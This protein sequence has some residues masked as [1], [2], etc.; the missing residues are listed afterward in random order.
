MR[1]LVLMSLCCFGAVAQESGF[2]LEDVARAA[3]VM[4]DGDLGI[5]EIHKRA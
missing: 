1:N 4:V 3:T 5:V 2:K